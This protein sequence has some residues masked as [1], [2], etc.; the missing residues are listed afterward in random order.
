MK[1]YEENDNGLIILILVIILQC[2]GMT[3]KAQSFKA[4]ENF[5]KSFRPQEISGANPWLSSSITTN[6]TGTL[7]NQ[8]LFGANITQVVDIDFAKIPLSIGYVNELVQVSASP[9]F[10]I[11]NSKVDMAIFHGGLKAFIDDSRNL[12]ILEYYLG[13]EYLRKLKNG[14]TITFSVGPYIEG[15]KVLF[16]FTSIIPLNNSLGLLIDLRGSNLNIGI[17][18][19]KKL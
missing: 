19:A 2:W 8:I 18:L 11:S 16:N 1:K 13:V 6:L 15:K 17:V 4:L 3:L 14:R 12:D 10:I 9:Y 5:D 7:E